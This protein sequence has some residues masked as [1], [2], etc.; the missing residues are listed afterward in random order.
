MQNT[1]SENIPK[2]KNCNFLNL[3]KFGEYE[4]LDE[5]NLLSFYRN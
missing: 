1:R 4:K 3:M 5:E 2:M